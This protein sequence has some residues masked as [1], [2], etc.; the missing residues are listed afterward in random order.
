M[1]N[2][3]TP[4]TAAK[5]DPPPQDPPLA[6]GYRPLV[7]TASR[8][9]PGS[10]S[11]DPLGGPRSHRSPR[12]RRGGGRNSFGMRASRSGR[13]AS[14]DR[15]QEGR[16]ERAVERFRSVICLWGS[17]ASV[18]AVTCVFACGRGRWSGRLGDR[19]LVVDLR[20]DASDPGVGGL[21][22]AWGQG[23]GRRA[24]GAAPRGRGAAPSGHPPGV[25]AG[26]PDA[27]G[28]VLTT[29]AQGPLGRVRRDPGDVVAVAP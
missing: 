11:G 8:K 24:A 9:R 14:A 17:I 19:A 3:R 27:A 23:Q 10:S 4:S 12:P 2:P 15:D 6:E 29:A 22:I 13:C 25:A 21:P 28:G 16:H 7:P 1:G 20:C 18:R 5:N 26:G